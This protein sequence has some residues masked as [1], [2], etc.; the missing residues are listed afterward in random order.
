MR[1]TADHPRPRWQF[2]R[3]AAVGE[4]GT[5][6]ADSDRDG[7][8]PRPVR[9]ALRYVLL[10]SVALLLAGCLWLVATALLARH[11]AQAARQ[12]VA[13]LRTAIAQAD[14]PAA[15]RASDQLAAHAH[16]AHRLTTGPAWWLG[17]QLPW[18]GRPARSIR[19]CTAQADQLTSTVVQPLVGL[20][21][22][23]RPAALIDSGRVRLQ[24]LIDAAPVLRRAQA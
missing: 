6:A 15:R 12:S 11:Q 19:G 18:A 20:A 22:G 17:A 7:V 21:D 10:V 5:A 13:A 3:P 2:G 9:T 23:L 24:P 1:F 16:S 14:L 8:A 4:S